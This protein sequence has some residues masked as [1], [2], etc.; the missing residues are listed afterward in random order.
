MFNKRS[1]SAIYLQLTI[2]LSSASRML[3]AVLRRYMNYYLIPTTNFSLHRQS[4]EYLTQCIAKKLEAMDRGHGVRAE[5]LRIAL[6]L[7][8]RT[9]NRYLQALSEAGRAVRH[10]WYWFPVR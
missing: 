8:R 9:T 6:R 2:F 4:A 10:G 3:S 5:Q 7:S 1:P